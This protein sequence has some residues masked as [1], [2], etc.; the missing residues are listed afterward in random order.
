MPKEIISVRVEYSTSLGKW[1]GIRKFAE[2]NNIE[3]ANIDAMI[4][5]IAKVGDASL[6][7]PVRF[8]INDFDDLF[9]SVFGTLAHPCPHCEIHFECVECPLDDDSHGCC[10]EWS[11]VKEQLM[12]YEE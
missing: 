12:K 9:R 6:D 11:E 4:A 2:L 1:M 7:K 5:R 10:K 8:E 3:T